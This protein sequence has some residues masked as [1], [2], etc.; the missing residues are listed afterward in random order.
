LISII[1]FRLSNNPS[2]SQ[3]N[4]VN[5]VTFSSGNPSSELITPGRAASYATTDYGVSCDMNSYRYTMPK[6]IP[7]KPCASCSRP[8]DG[9]EEAGHGKNPCRRYPRFQ[10]L[11]CSITGYRSP[12]VSLDAPTSTMSYFLLMPYGNRGARWSCSDAE[13][14]A[15]WGAGSLAGPNPRNATSAGLSLLRL[16]IH[17]NFNATLK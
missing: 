14:G 10:V 7:A 6:K 1:G 12:T 16:R 3:R 2:I 13:P 9:I 4:Y 17:H 11:R 8:L 15:A 5:L